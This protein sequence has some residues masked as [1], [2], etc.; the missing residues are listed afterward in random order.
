M[1]IRF[2]RLNA[3]HNTEVKYECSNIPKTTTERKS[4]I[5]SDKEINWKHYF[6]QKKQIS[7]S[8]N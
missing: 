3:A 5:L 2:G 8:G 1:K 4:T 6:I 7:R